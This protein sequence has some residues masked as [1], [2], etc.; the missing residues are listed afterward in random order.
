MAIPSFDV[1]LDPSRHVSVAMATYNGMPYLPEQLESILAQTRPADEIVICDDCSTDDTWSYLEQQSKKH[2]TIRLFR[3]DHNLRSTRNFERAIRE[4][5]GNVI[6]LSD[7]DDL[8]AATKIEAQLHHMLTTGAVLV[9]SDGDLVDAMGQKMGATLWQSN[10]ITD[11]IKAQLESDSPW[12]VLPFNFFITGCAT[13]FDTSLRRLFVPI[14]AFAWH[15]A[16]IAAVA[17]VAHP[18]RI[19]LMEQ[20]LIG[21]RQHGRNQIGAKATPLWNG[22]LAVAN[23]KMERIF[24]ELRSFDD[25]KCQSHFVAALIERTQHR[26][27]PKVA[28]AQSFLRAIAEGDKH[29]A[30]RISYVKRST[31]LLRIFHPTML[32]GYFR[33]S[34]GITT[35][36]RDILVRLMRTA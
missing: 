36:I 10:G 12:Q 18:G 19:A 13:C 17:S 15:D 4:C 32:A 9:M 7:Q 2:P 31:S 14:P 23:S 5:T 25:V 3:N 24:R 35:I 11:R 8:W 28:D 29:C 6:F 34:K 21:Y 16:W 20:K 27:F 33:Y 30:R 26:D 22:G 1:R